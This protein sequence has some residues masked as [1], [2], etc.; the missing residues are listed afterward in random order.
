MALDPLDQA[1]NGF[2]ESM[3]KGKNRASYTGSNVARLIFVV[4]PHVVRQISNVKTKKIL[5]LFL[6]IVKLYS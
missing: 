6:L 2:V 1:F 4:S 3:V 5:T